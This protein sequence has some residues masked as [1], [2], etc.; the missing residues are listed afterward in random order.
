[1]I[2]VIGLGYVGLPLAV[3]LSEAG[4]GVTGYDV[5]SQ[6]IKGLKNGISPI[7][8]IDSPRLQSALA[9]GLTVTN[10]AEELALCDVFIICVPTPLSMDRKVDTSAIDSAVAVIAPHLRPGSLVVLESTSYPGTTEEIVAAPLAETTGLVAGVDFCVGFSP[11]RIDPGNPVYEVSNTPK[12]VSGLAACCLERVSELYGFVSISVVEAAGVREAELAKLLE[13]T[14]R[15]INI[16]LVNEM[17][18]F[19]RGLGVDLR[20][21]IRL[22]ATKPFGF[23][24]FYPGPGVGGHCIPIDPH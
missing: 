10:S 22:A 20:E 15:H 4:K 9:N 8:D 16:A 6:L 21:A 14:Y 19:S 12:V 3:S 18:K 24:P 5:N 13:N 11:E 23:E 2:A 7:G 1:M 17:S